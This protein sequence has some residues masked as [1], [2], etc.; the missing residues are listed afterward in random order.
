MITPRSFAAI[1]RHFD[2][3]DRAVSL[4]L[5][6]H[7]A[8]S[9]PAL[10]T[11]L[12]RMMSQEHQVE[13]RIDY[14]IDDLNVELSKDNG[15]LSL[16][17]S[18]W[19]YGPTVENLVTQ[20]D[21]GL[22]VEYR[23]SLRP[24]NSVKRGWLLQ[25]KKLSP[26]GGPPTGDPVLDA[27]GYSESS[28]FSAYDKEQHQR[29]QKLA[30][31]LSENA[32]RFLYYCPRMD[33]LPA[34]LQQKLVYLR[35]QA[36][37]HHIFDY[38]PGLALRDELMAGGGS[39]SA[40]IFVGGAGQRHASQFG[41]LFEGLFTEYVPFSWFVAMEAFMLA[42][43]PEARA[44]FESLE[45]RPQSISGSVFGARPLY[46]DGGGVSDGI[47]VFDVIGGNQDA[48]LKVCD[49]LGID[50]DAKS[51]FR[52]FP[53]STLTVGVELDSSLTLDLRD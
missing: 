11:D 1:L 9:E 51:P 21:L 36:L 19:E 18:T 25:A 40:G 42:V 43:N 52:V 45:L 33:L 17:L 4:G 31:V 48:M 16:S 7:R 23:D 37:A 24:R 30:G 3:I 26:H 27:P 53:A 49:Q 39:L 44:F 15:P 14:T 8:K 46:H 2:Q 22:I 50:R 38:T 20:S 10:T 34:D 28:T 47:D 32:L 12:A 29:M 35:A 41:S 6:G 13:R 5:L